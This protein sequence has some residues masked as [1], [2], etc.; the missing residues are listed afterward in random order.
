M[1]RALATVV[2]VITLAAG[3]S[4]AVDKQVF[5]PTLIG[6]CAQ[7]NERVEAAPEEEQPAVAA[8]ELSSLVSQVRE[9]AAP[10]EDS[11]LL[12]DMLQS[13]DETADGFRAAAEAGARGNAELADAEGSAAQARLSRT[14]DLATEY[15]MPPLD[16]CDEVANSEVPWPIAASTPRAPTPSPGPSGS[17]P[18]VEADGPGWTRLADART[19]RQQV[20]A[21]RVGGLVY[22]AGGVLDGTGTDRVEAL[23]PT[24][25]RWQSAPELPIPLHDAMAVTYGGNMI[26]LGGWRSDG[27]EAKAEVSDR[28]LAL[29]G[30]RWIDLPRLRQPR[31]G[32]AA[33]VIQGTIVVVGGYDEDGLIRE[34]EIYDRGDGA[35]QAGPDLPTPRRDL[36]A[37]ANRRHVYALG[38]R[39]LATDRAFTTA[40]RLDPATGQWETLAP[41]GTARADLAAGIV[42]GR[43]VAVGGERPTGALAAVE[44]FDP[45]AGGWT[46]FPPLPM[47]L[48]GAGVA[49]VGDVLYVVNG[50]AA[51]ALA[52]PTSFA[53]VLRPPARQR[54]AADEW[55]PIQAASLA[56]QQVATAEIDG[57]IWVVGGLERID[58]ATSSV[59]HVDP[60]TGEWT[61]APDLPEPLHHAMAVGLDGEL[62]VLGGWVG[63]GANPTSETSDRVYALRGDTWERLASLNR[64]RAAGAAAVVDGQIVVAGGVADGERVRPTEVYDPAADAWEDRANIPTPR[65]HLAVGAHDG[66]VYAA[67]GWLTGK[68]DNSDA[69]ERYDPATDE[70][71]ELERMPT[72][73]GSV[74]GAMIDGQLLVVGGETNEG[75]LDTVELYDV[76]SG[77]WRDG[78]SLPSARHGPGAAAAGSLVCVIGGAQRRGHNRSTSAVD[79]LRFE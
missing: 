59:S 6:F 50:G 40:E 74:A 27:D 13:F 28:V 49:T 3:C 69:L 10:T 15:G 18:E 76:A 12:E 37:A 26:V 29:R 20:A 53:A 45:E 30:S 5:L 16:Q 56:R 34:T 41:L 64:P 44:A 78:P 57:E 77:E 79:V 31:A 51:P 35:W 68:D 38:G 66:A 43:V 4:Q 17:E 60:Q 21:A 23:D 19:A 65:E 58:V 24:I 48:H 71:T 72:P 63:G 9:G 61:Q 7:V 2:V 46:E 47:A 67:G 25:R 39:N 11:E 1:R 54:R 52:D 14:S 32:G 36:A 62:V 42:D 55:D 73:R 8:S 70:W 22:V 33:A 75:V